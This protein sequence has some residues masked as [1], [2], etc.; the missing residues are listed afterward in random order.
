[1]SALDAHVGTLVFKEA[2][3]TFLIEEKRSVVLVTHQTQFLPEVD[4]VS[5]ALQSVK[6]RE[7]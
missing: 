6:T 5:V 3:K 4:Y 2:L 1:M 7:D